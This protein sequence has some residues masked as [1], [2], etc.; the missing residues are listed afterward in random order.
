MMVNNFVN[1]FCVDLTSYLKPKN[2]T[3]LLSIQYLK[4]LGR[5]SLLVG[6]H[7][8]PLHKINQ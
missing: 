4:A 2:W 6:R 5:V 8:C 7:D 3:N 1:M